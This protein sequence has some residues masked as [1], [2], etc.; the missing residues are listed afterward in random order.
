M[1]QFANPLAL[2]ALAGLSIPIAIHFLSRKEGKVI[3]IGSIRHLEET[4]TQKFKG[5]RLNEILLLILRCLC[6][7]VFTLMLA[8]LQ[9]STEDKGSERWLLLEKGLEED[10]RIKT[11]R[12]SLEEQGF[13][14]RFLSTGFPT[15]ENTSEAKSSYYQLVNA[16]VQ[17]NL[18][19]AVIVSFN[20]SHRFR[21]QPC[22]LPNTVQWISMPASPSTYEVNTWITSFDSSYTRQGYSKE[23]VT[24]FET[25]SR[26][27]STQ[28]L[29]SLTRERAKQVAIFS[30]DGFEADM[31]IVEAA[32]RSLQDHQHIELQFTSYKI[33][34][35][36][37]IAMEME[38]IFWLSNEP[39]PTSLRS[40]LFYLQT[41]LSNSILKQESPKRWRITKRLHPEI[42]LK[43]NF[44]IQLA[45]LLLASPSLEKV[46]EEND[47]RL[48]PD[49][50]AW[51][52]GKSESDKPSFAAFQPADSY[53]LYL[54][55]GLLLIERLL[56]YQRKQ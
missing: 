22:A 42:A 41:D 28:E 4:T 13:E 21:G 30:E 53:L 23:D 49:S 40:N 47:A 16:L 33:S 14:T 18:E 2:W 1:I 25:T 24:Y 36:T 46:V 55:L 12:D 48:M 8:G 39:V 20:K 9:F 11:L 54:L 29:A 15:L 43:E 37:T 6:I 34:E 10:I 27:V 50:L 45:S 44:T 5:I 26:K 51:L 19:K 32:L 52:P 38:Y 35:F 31:R 56:A 17:H 7:I 3:R